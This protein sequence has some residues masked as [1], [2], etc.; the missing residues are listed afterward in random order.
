MTRIPT[1][2]RWALACVLGLAL[3]W[4]FEAWTR[5]E[6]VFNVTSFMSFCP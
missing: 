3:V 4:A 2:T 5:P 1:F 6:L